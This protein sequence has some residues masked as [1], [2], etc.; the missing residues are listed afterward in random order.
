MIKFYITN[1]QKNSLTAKYL[2]IICFTKNVK[3]LTVT[4]A[5]AGTHQYV[6]I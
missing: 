6:T 3:C 4:Y 2:K 1:L 5:H